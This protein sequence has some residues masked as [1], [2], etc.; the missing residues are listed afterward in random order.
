MT[1]AAGVCEFVFAEELL[2]GSHS[3]VNKRAH[4]LCRILDADSHSLDQPVDGSRIDSE[5]VQTV[6][7]PWTCVSDAIAN[8][9]IGNVV[10]A[11]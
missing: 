11:R 10:K 8:I 6:V 3:C 9:G 2:K 7:S 5:Q 4:P 1:F